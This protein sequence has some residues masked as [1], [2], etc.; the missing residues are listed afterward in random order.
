MESLAAVGLAANILQ[1]IHEAR[2]LVSTSREI[3]G[4]GTKDEYIELELISK[5]LRS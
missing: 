4:S 1:F 5:E 3:L 2:N